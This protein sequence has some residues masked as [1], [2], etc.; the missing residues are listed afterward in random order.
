MTYGKGRNKVRGKVRLH[1]KITRMIRNFECLIVVTSAPGVLPEQNDRY[2][3]QPWK[4]NEIRAYKNR[5]NR[6]SEVSEKVDKKGHKG[7]RRKKN[8]WDNWGHM[9]H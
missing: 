7:N 9:V 2:G 1:T 6:T 8:Y 5:A 4:V 3:I